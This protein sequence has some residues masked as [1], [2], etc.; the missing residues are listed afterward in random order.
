[1]QV[2]ENKNFFGGPIYKEQ[3]QYEPRKPD[4]QMYFKRATVYTKA[5]TGWLN[6]VTG[7]TDK[8]S[9]AMDYNPEILDHFVEWMGGGLGRLMT[10]SLNTGASLL[11]EKDMPEVGKLPVVRQLVKGPQEYKD[12][13][14]VREMV[15]ESGRKIFNQQEVQNYQDAMRR[16]V[17]AGTITT[18][19]QKRYEKEVSRNQADAV[20]SKQGLATHDEIVQAWED[21]FTR[22]KT[23]RPPDRMAELRKMITDYNKQ[24]SSTGQ[25]T[26]TNQALMQA[27]ERGVKSQ[28]KAR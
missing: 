19:Q 20:A 11:I 5:L 24:A 23:E 9:G 8:V 4:S 1:V 21:Y 16:A 22:P 3:G 28:R 13:G 12:P 17:A 25:Q 14:T 27:S 26:I 2:G 7:G 6:R 15:K 10:N 18:E